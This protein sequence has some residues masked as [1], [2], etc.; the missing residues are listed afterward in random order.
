MVYTKAVNTH[1]FNST[2]PHMHYPMR[3]WREGVMHA[4]TWTVWVGSQSFLVVGQSRFEI[5]LVEGNTGLAQQSRDV[6]RTLALH[7]CSY[8]K[9]LSKHVIHVYTLASTPGRSVSN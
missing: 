9:H 7:T 8:D 6:V 1:T 5:L 4:L 2:P 3:R